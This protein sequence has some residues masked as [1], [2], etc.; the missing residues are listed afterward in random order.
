MMVILVELVRRRGGD[1][2]DATRASTGKFLKRLQ[3]V[4]NK[5]R[6]EG[7]TWKDVGSWKDDVKPND[8][9]KAKA[10]GL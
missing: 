1:L 7:K 4:E 5:M 10:A 3:F 8:W 9:D 6:S 2:D